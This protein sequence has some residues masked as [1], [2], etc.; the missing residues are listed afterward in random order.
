MRRT[1]QIG[2]PDRRRN[3]Y[4]LASAEGFFNTIDVKRTSPTVTMD[5]VVGG[6]RPFKYAS[7][8]PGDRDRGARTLQ[9]RSFLRRP[10][11]INASSKPGGKSINRLERV[12]PTFPRWPSPSGPPA[13]LGSAR[14]DASASAMISFGDAA[15]FGFAVKMIRRALVQ[16]AV[17]WSGSSK[18]AWLA[19]C[20]ARAYIC[21]HPHSGRTNREHSLTSRRTLRPRARRRWSPLPP[22]SR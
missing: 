19:R 5:V 1:A 9:R 18:R 8:T 4:P 14:R 21:T 20:I 15:L 22:P 6:L 10:S 7:S 16:C 13:K 17:A 2:R 11:L 12:Q 3:R